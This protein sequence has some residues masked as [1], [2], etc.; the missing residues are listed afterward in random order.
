M[1][2][3]RPFRTA[4]WATPAPEG[5]YS[6]CWPEEAGRREYIPSAGALVGQRKA[7]SSLGP[8]GVGCQCVHFRLLRSCEV[9][10]RAQGASGGLR[11]TNW[12]NA[13][14]TTPPQVSSCPRGSTSNT[15]KQIIL[16][17]LPMV[18]CP[19]FSPLI[20]YYSW[21]AA[22]FSPLISYYPWLAAPFSPLFSLYDSSM[23]AAEWWEYRWS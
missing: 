1:A 5:K 20:S 10:N 15:M 22:P 4:R 13:L 19:P 16:L 8:C 2:I 6:L 3:S 11:Q 7:S 14:D 17:P 9:A 12:M 18:G 21:L 23:F